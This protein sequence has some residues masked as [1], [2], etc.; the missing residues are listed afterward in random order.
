MP[1]LDK[2]GSSILAWSCFASLGTLGHRLVEKANQLGYFLRV[3][4]LSNFKVLRKGLFFT[5]REL[6]FPT[7]CQ[8]GRRSTVL[9]SH[10]P[11]HPQTTRKE[12]SSPHSFGAT[13]H[14]SGEICVG[15][16]H[17]FM[18]GNADHFIVQR[19]CC[20]SSQRS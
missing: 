5:V 3:F 9:S 11:L 6:A 13:T 8:F 7:S 4:E 18:V 1:Q 20:H 19:S 2:R 15:H 10:P 17:N 14:L 12:N 16:A